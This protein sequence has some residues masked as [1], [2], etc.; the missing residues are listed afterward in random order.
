MNKKTADDIA[1]FIKDLRPGDQL[2][3]EFFQDLRCLSEK[4]TELRMLEA[5]WCKYQ[6]KDWNRIIQSQKILINELRDENSDL[7]R[8]RKMNTTLTQIANGF[9]FGSGLILAA[10]LFRAILHS[11]FCG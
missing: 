3:A 1:Y 6:F 2:Y 11:G 7:K 5:D 4:F 8:G 10:M 9:L